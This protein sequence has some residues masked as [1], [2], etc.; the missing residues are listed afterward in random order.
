MK[1]IHVF[2]PFL[3]G[4]QIIAQ[5]TPTITVGSTVTD[6]AGRP[7]AGVA[8]YGDEGMAKTMTD[9]LGRFSFTVAV[10]SD[11]M[12]EKKGYQRAVFPSEWYADGGKFSLTASEPFF[13]EDD[14][15]NVG[16]G[17]IHKGSVVNGIAVLRPGEI[18]GYDNVL[19]VEEAINGRIAGMTGSSN[20]RGIGT[21]VFI[22]DGVPREPAYLNINDIEEITALKDVNAAIMYGNTGAAG[23]VLITTKRG[24]AMKNGVNVSGHYGIAQPRALP[25]YLSSADYMEQYNTARIND[26]LTP[27][28]DQTTID[29]YR[30]GNPYR[31]PSIDYY[32]SEFLKKVKPFSKI[33]L[34]LSG[35]N[36]IAAYYSCV[37]WDRQD[38][39]LNFG[40][41]QSMHNNTFNFRG[42]VDLRINRRITS[43][44]DAAG[45]ISTE[46]GPLINGGASDYWTQAATSRPDRFSPFIPIELVDPE[47][48]LL[49]GR[50][51]DIDGQYLAG[52]TSDVLTNPIADVYLGGENSRVLRNL[53]FTNKVDIDLGGLLDGLGF[54]TNISFDYLTSYYQYI[55][56]EY[57]VYD[58][59]W[60]ANIDKVVGLVKYGEDVRSGVQNMGA[61]YGQR[62]FGLYLMLDYHQT[63]GEAH[64]LSNALSLYSNNIKTSS[65]VQANKNANLGL[66]VQYDYRHKYM[67]EFGGALVSSAKLPKKNRTAFSPSLGLAWMIG[68]ED[69]MAGAD[70]VDYL[71]IKL[72]GG[73]MNTDAGLDYF[74]YDDYYV[75]SGVLTWYEYQSI[76]QGMIPDHERNEQLFFEKRKDLNIGI[77]GA[78]FDGTLTFDACWFINTRAD[79]VMQTKTLYPSYYANYTPFVNYGKNRYSGLE[80]GLSVRQTFGR[81]GVVAGGNILYADSKILKTDEMYANDYQ[82]RKGNPVDAVYGLVADGFF[83][84]RDEVEQHKT[85]S[86]GFVQQ[87]DI[88]YANQNGDMVIDEN[89]EKM[90]G[91]SQAPFSFGVQLQLSYG[92]F[93]LFASGT[94]RTGA[95]G[96]LNG[97]YY[98]VQGDGKYSAYMLHHWTEANKNT[99][100]YPRLSSNNNNNNFRSSSFWLYKD[101]YF[102]VDR[103]QLNYDVPL[104]NDNKI[105]LKKLHLFANVANVATIA[106]NKEIRILNIGTEPQY[107]TF[108]IGLKAMF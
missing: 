39:L 77:E 86:F 10:G 31:Y 95:D 12:M 93:S 108:S 38:N 104:K 105:T 4:G 71:K 44:I 14:L 96:A 65:D 54:H 99:A 24:Q 70:F 84:S 49:Q 69:F 1:A 72:S 11:L 30:Y 98:W 27:A 92:R 59:A 87:G 51:R 29:H 91:R 41:V 63:F 50:K 53:S 21:P 62:R 40:N 18:L 45:F 36:K 15:T 83:M 42:N 80:M 61:S 46:N 94:G 23:I 68:S 26:G 88:R 3:L 35:G 64:H 37:S 6:E 5:E 9:S 43:S 32:S 73:I 79:I 67:A 103:L 28:Y 101:D 16:F 89:D 82:Y 7:I 52:G 2:L 22:V 13:G 58:A 97:S 25:D 81:F 74:L 106:P 57:A 76:G 85:Q 17:K 33:Q 34:D 78:L 100:N 75:Y 19:T 90:I 48:S 20:L 8:I 107:R 47:L 102:N 66:R 56:N 60:D 55:N